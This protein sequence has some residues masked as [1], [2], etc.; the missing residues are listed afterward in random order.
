[1]LRLHVF[2][3]SPRAFKVIA[4]AHHLGIDYEMKFVD[5]TKGEHTQP[6]HT[7]LNINAKMPVLEHDGFVLW[8]S[9][10]IL[11]YLAAFKGDANVLPHERQPW[12]TVNQWMFWESAHWDPACGALAFENFAKSLFGKG[13]PDPAEVA[14]AEP[15]FHRFATVLDQSLKGNRFITGAN[16]T[17]A[18]FSIGAWMTIAEPAK[19]PVGGYREILRW[20]AEL[21]ELPAWRKALAIAHE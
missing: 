12:S 2:P 18:D 14:K 8:E 5:L 6:D 15:V 19:Y 16:L 1:M 21:S 3:G 7:A 10:A 17:V 20:Y 9:N 4:L 13:G 11:Q